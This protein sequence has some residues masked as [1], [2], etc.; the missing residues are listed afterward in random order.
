MQTIFQ[1]SYISATN[2]NTIKKDVMLEYEWIQDKNKNKMLKLYLQFGHS[3][4][5]KIW[6]LLRVV[7][8]K[9]FFKNMRK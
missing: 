5:D 3:S 7:E 1:K 6:N 2:I 9:V 4:Y 8:M